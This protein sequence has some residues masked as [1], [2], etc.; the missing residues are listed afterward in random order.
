MSKEKI[1]DVNPPPFSRPLMVSA[2]PPEGLDV[3]LSPDA[4]ERAALARENGLVAVHELEARL[5]VARGGAEG[6]EVAGHLHAR[7]RQTCVVTLE[8]FDAVVD[9]PVRLRFAP[10]SGSASK[11]SADEEK[12]TFVELDDEAPDPLIGGVVDLGAVACEFLTLGLDP[13]PR[14]PGA[15]FEEPA[16]PDGGDSPFSQLLQR[17]KDGAGEGGP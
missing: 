12:A 4:T 3:T 2:V 15:H 11:M 13:Y 17:A 5:R 6:L 7:I 10:Q 1:R 16:P 8:D 9:E 14:R